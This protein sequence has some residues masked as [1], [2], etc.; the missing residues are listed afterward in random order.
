ME[1]L[2]VSSETI[3]LALELLQSAVLGLNDVVQQGHLALYGIDT[4]AKAL[5]LLG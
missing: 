4:F 2:D 3:G 5:I 1:S